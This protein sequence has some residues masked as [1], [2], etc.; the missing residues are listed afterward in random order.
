MDFFAGW[1]PSLNME[2]NTFIIL[3]FYTV[4]IIRSECSS[5]IFYLSTCKNV[6]P[7]S[8]LYAFLKLTTCRKI[9]NAFMLQIS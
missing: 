9:L 8:L 1:I 4:S 2:K 7:S 6:I 5:V 3:L